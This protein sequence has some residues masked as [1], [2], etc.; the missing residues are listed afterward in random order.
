[1]QDNNN[2]K[3]RCRCHPGCNKLRSKQTRRRHYQRVEDKDGILPSESETDTS[4]G[5]SND[6]FPSMEGEQNDLYQHFT[7]SPQNRSPSMAID[8]PLAEGGDN[9]DVDE[10]NYES[11]MDEDSDQ[12]NYSDLPD[13]VLPDFADGVEDPL[14]FGDLDFAEEDIERGLTLE[15]M[16]QELEDVVGGDMDE[17]LHNASK[18]K[19]ALLKNNLC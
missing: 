17:A 14:E 6:K 13:L 1:M 2:K 3:K 5:D 12:V 16:Q 10:A 18:L 19:A 11:G 15:E 7:S 4:S 9:F 8:V